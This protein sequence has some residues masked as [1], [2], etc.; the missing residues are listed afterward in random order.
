MNDANM[1]LDKLKIQQ[2]GVLS[3]NLLN[4]LKIPLFL[5]LIGNLLFG[6][7]LYLRVRILIDTFSS[8]ENKMIQ[9]IV[10]GYLLLTIIGSLLAV[11]FLILS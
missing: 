5:F 8:N 6:L 1:F 9:K 3:I 10:F 7:L 2:V 11:L 4:I